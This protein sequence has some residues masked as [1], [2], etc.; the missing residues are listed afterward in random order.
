[1]ITKSGVMKPE[2]SRSQARRFP[3]SCKNGFVYSVIRQGL[4]F[5]FHRSPPAVPSPRPMRLCQLVCLFK[6]RLRQVNE[7]VWTSEPTRY[8]SRLAV[9]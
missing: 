5:S 8:M 6:L 1:M 3:E 4:H 2:R 7:G 9:A